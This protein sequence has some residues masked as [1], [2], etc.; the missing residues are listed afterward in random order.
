MLRERF[1]LSRLP[2]ELRGFG[3][4]RT[5]LLGRPRVPAGARLA[6]AP[7][8]VHAFGHLG[9]RPTEA[10]LRR[11]CGYRAT[12]GDVVRLR[13]GG[14]TGH[15][16]SDPER[17]R[18][19]LQERH[20][21][22]S[23]AT[24]GFLKL[25]LVLGL[26]LLTAEGESWLRNRRIAQP[27][28]ARRRLEGFA[29]RM[30]AAGEA[31]VAGWR[32]GEVLA[33]HGEKHAV[34]LR[35]V[36]ETMFGAD[37]GH[38]AGEVAAAVSVVTNDVNQRMRS[39]VELPL[40]VPTPQNQRFTKAMDTLDRIVLGLIQERRREPPGT[41]DDLLAM[42]MAARDVAT[43]EGM[44]D[45]QLRDEVMTIFLAGHE[46]TANALSWT[47]LLLSR[48]PESARRLR[49]EVDAV[50]A[51]GRTPTHEYVVPRS[52]PTLSPL[53]CA[54]LLLLCGSLVATKHFARIRNVIR[55]KILWMRA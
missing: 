10:F 24:R 40:A 12:H 17:V 39:R 50:L 31:M 22:Y 25:R 37:L 7:E 35:I 8:R 52:L 2:E 49:E 29:E 15:L 18:G 51:G 21:L 3:D 6:P 30:A 28:F 5:A 23:T 9:M 1:A 4:P 20:R 41:R 27:A 34:T 14:I 16:I 47:L 36:S 13:F 46:T 42:L 19:V 45:T 11:L 48:H 55:K 33:A 43:G 32:D 44:S 38:L 54:I 26:G 53:T